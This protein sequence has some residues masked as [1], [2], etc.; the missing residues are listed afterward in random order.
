[1]A[2]I[3]NWV[4]EGFPSLSAAF[5]ASLATAAAAVADKE[6]EAEAERE[7]GSELDLAWAGEAHRNRRLF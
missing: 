7:G 1:M 5:P 2:R 4:H 3:V 6:A